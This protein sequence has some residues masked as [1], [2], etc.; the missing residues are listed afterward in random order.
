M[1]EAM[2]QL[3]AGQ[4][5]IGSIASRKKIKDMAYVAYFRD[6]GKDMTTKQVPD[7][8]SLAWVRE[9]IRKADAMKSQGAN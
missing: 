3:P 5:G 8:Q 1:C 7:P 9:E 4:H 2:E 6:T